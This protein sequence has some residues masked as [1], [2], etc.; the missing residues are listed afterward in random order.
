[1]DN[2]PPSRP[3]EYSPN[4]DGVPNPTGTGACYAV[5]T[6]AGEYSHIGPWGGMDSLIPEPDTG[7]FEFRGTLIDG[8][9][10][11]VREEIS[12]DFAVFTARNV[13]VNPD[14]F[15]ITPQPH[16]SLAEVIR[17]NPIVSLYVTAEAGLTLAAVEAV[18]VISLD[19]VTLINQVVIETSD[20]AIIRLTGVDMDALGVGTLTGGAKIKQ[21]SLLAGGDSTIK[22]GVHEPIMGM[23]CQGGQVLPLGVEVGSIIYAATGV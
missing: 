6:S 11:E 4:P 9:Q 10:V 1:M 8:T 12:G 20:S 3:P 14:D 23:V 18:Q 17:N 5:I 2:T 15:A 22:D 16:V 7:F 13:P 19:P 21:S